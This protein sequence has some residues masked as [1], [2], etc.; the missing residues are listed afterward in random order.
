MNDYGG[1]GLCD[2]LRDYPWM[3]VRPAS[4]ASLHIEGQF[5]FTAS[6]ENHGTI[7]DHYQLRIAVPSL[8]PRELPVVYEIGGRIPQNGRYHVNRDDGSLCLGSRL[9]VLCKLAQAP[10]L[11]GFT[12]KCLVP[13]LFAVS[14]KLL[15]GGDWLFE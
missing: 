4:D 10:T 2:F 11:V 3:V 5:D 6:F 1:M 15:H 14:H 13:Y 8:F 7:T 12:E 9:R